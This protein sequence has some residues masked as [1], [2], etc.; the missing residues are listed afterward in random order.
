[1]QRGRGAKWLTVDVMWTE[2]NQRA[3]SSYTMR[4]AVHGF[5][6]GEDSMTHW[7]QSF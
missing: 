5:E 4:S 3:I 1:M 6:R 2:P 7:M